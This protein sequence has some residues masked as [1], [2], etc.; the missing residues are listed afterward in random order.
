MYVYT[1]ILTIKTNIT[2]IG[3]YWFLPL[4]LGD[5]RLTT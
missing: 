4:P 1:A 2:S 5:D 3:N